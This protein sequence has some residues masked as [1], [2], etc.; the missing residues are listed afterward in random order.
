ML[1][2]VSAYGHVSQRLC[3]NSLLILDRFHI[4]NKLKKVINKTRSIEADMLR[5]KGDKVTLSKTRWA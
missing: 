4:V 5:R 2:H 1:G 3:P